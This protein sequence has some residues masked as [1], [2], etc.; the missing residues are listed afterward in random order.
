MEIPIEYTLRS[1]APR[2]RCLRCAV[3]AARCQADTKMWDSTGKHGDLPES[4]GSMWMENVV[5]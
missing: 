1:Q 3:S 5:E 2:G 4:M